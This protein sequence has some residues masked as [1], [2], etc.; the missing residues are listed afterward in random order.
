MKS[1]ALATLLSLSAATAMAGVP[2]FGLPDLT[3][4]APTPQPDISTQ[5]CLPAD[6]CD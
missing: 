3:F 6:A 4:P 2:P 1:L 5:G